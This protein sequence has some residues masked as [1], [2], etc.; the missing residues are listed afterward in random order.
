LSDLAGAVA[1]AGKALSQNQTFAM[2]YRCI[3]SALAHPGH[4]AEASETAAGLLELEPDFRISEWMAR[5]GRWE[6]QTFIDGLRKAGL[7]E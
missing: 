3:A 6:A 1:A 2:S 7:P 4:K 5:G